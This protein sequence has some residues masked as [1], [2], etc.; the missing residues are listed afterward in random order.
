MSPA[1][2]RRYAQRL[3]VEERRPQLLDAALE[4]IVELGYTGATLDVIARRAG[5]TKPVI[6]AAF[7]DR[8]AFLAALL[9]R[10]EARVLAAITGALPPIEAVTGRRE[11]ADL[12]ARGVTSLLR[13][14]AAEPAPWLLIFTES[15]ATPE[16]VR[17]RIARDRA[18]IHRG[19]SEL[20]AR[21]ATT[22]GAEGLDPNLVA[23]AFF[24]IVERFAR[25][26]ADADPSLDPEA[27]GA[28]VAALA[29]GG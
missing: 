22:V 1:P 26:A 24:A 18:L 8:D 9:D 3:S 17:H 16:P 19:L 27:A 13:V 11:L 21:G 23:H 10:E 28:V 29:T 6:Y 7:T 2:E 25:L 5:V 12:I 4:A 20:I 15:D 14:V